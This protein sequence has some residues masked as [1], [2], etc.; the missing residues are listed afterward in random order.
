[1][2]LRD[3]DTFNLKELQDY[4]AASKVA[5]QYWPEKVEVVDQL[6]VTPAGKIQKFKLKEIAKKFAA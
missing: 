3:G 1:V 5:K 6:P 4:M 2:V